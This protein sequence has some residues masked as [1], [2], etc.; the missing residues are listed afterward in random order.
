MHQEQITQLIS[1]RVNED[2]LTETGLEGVQLFRATQT[3][4]CTPAVYEPCI[5]AITSGAKEAILDGARFVYDSQHYMCCPMSM[6]V[7]AGTSHAS[8]ET[9]LYGVLISLNPRV[10]RELT[11]EIENAGGGFPS[12]ADR[13]SIQGIS[14][15]AWDLTFSDA[16]F[17]LLQ[18]CDNE[19]DLAVL[20]D[21]RLRE[22]Y[23]AI[24]KGNAGVFARQAFS[25]GNAIAR[26]IA[27]V[28]A[29]MNEQFPSMN[30]RHVQE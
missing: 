3:I 11:V 29:N 5:V 8:P 14:L 15:A 10:M 13:S 30:W 22:L 16:L 25:V 28:S 20:G 19:T 24:L 26:A 18:I 21:A 23:Y 9:P 1:D 17:R 27:H 2:G 7:M 12:L 4:P 6:P